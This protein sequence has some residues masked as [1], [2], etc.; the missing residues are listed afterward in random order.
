MF[1]PESLNRNGRGTGG[2]EVDVRKD[3]GQ[4]D[5]TTDEELKG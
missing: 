3:T 5:R 4:G 2:R 1:L